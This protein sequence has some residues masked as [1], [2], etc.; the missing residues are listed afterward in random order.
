[1]SCLDNTQIA[2]YVSS[3]GLTPEERERYGKHLSDCE[4]CRAEVDRFQRDARDEDCAGVRPMLE[5]HALGEA[6]G[7]PSG[8]VLAHARDCPS[9]A[10][11]L[12]RLSV[13]YSVEEVSNWRIPVPEELHARIEAQLDKA[14]GAARAGAG[15]HALVDKV[16]DFALPSAFFSRHSL[17]PSRFAAR[18]IFPKATSL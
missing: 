12:S 4:R 5:S 11:L 3:F 17:R 16:R 14:L 10:E 18:T 6:S 13:S 15:T 8:A 9:C 2:L 7:E 1:M